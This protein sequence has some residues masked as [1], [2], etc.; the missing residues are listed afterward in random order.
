MG[1]RTLAVTCTDV[2]VR[3]RPEPASLTRVIGRTPTRARVGSPRKPPNVV[4][5]T[6]MLR[7]SGRVA[8]DQGPAADQSED[9]DS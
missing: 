3:S 2:V 5:L 1:M 7:G 4:L 9:E 8:C 6:A